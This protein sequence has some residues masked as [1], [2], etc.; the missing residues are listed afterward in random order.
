MREWRKEKKEEKKGQDGKG[1]NTNLTLNQT[2]RNQ[3]PVIEVRS[4]SL[5]EA[6]EAAFSISK[7]FLQ[8]LT[9]AV[10]RTVLRPAVPAITPWSRVKKLKKIMFIFV[11]QLDAVLIFLISSHDIAFFFFQSF[12]QYNKKRTMGKFIVQ[13]ENIVK[14]EIKAIFSVKS[15]NW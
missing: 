11:M 7:N 5:S 8:E 13:V 4:A 3:V 6:A 2:S 12:S 9:K 14:I 15:H 1:K 10:T